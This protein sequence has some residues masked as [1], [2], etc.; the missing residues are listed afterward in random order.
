MNV[1]L[2]FRPRHSSSRRKDAHQKYKESTPPRRGVKGADSL[3]RTCER[4][5]NRELALEAS[6]LVPSLPQNS[7]TDEMRERANADSFQSSLTC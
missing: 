2:T 6:N 4:R 1:S 3:A 5:T 7:V